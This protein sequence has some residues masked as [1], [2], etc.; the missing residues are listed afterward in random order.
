MDAFAVVKLKYVR[1]LNNTYML[2]DKVSDSYVDE[3]FK[4]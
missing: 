4:V 1:S 3:Y 2:L